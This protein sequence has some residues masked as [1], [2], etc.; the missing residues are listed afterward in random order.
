MWRGWSRI[1]R[2][3]AQA[4]RVSPDVDGTRVTPR[5]WFRHGPHDRDPLA[6]S[7][8]PPDNRWQRG[9]VVAALYLASDAATAWA[10]WY[11]HLAELGI[12]P[13]QQM[14]RDL[15]TWQVDRGLEVAD[16]STAER[17]ARVGLD[18]PQP[19]RATWLPYQRVGE[20]LWRAGWRGIVAPSAARPSKGLVLCL[21]RDTKDGLAARPVPPPL[22][23]RDPPAP[24]TGLTT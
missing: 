8:P 17:L 1:S 13:N 5:R 9:K 18:P 15:W 12:P 3:R 22:L 19:D 4:E 14:P 10:E 7:N 2:I 6:R 20:A 23:V 21:F 24:P 16:L 11:R